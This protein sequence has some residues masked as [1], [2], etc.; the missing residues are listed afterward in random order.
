M[1]T[2]E[3]IVAKALE[4]FNERSVEYVGLRELAAVLGMRVSNIT[5]YFPT[6]DDLVNRLVLDLSRLN[7]AL[8]HRGVDQTLLS[9]LLM[10][11]KVFENQIKYRCLL[12]SFVQ[13]MEQNKRVAAKY[14]ETQQKRRTILSDDLNNLIRN[15]YFNEKGAAQVDFLISTLALVSRFWISEAAVSYRHLSP[16]AQMNHYLS[17]V[18]R[19]FLPYV[20]PKGEKEIQEFLQGLGQI[21]GGPQQN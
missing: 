5:Y 4:M 9:F 7:S 13:I 15:G 11:Q 12:L 20:S 16:V 18:A 8:E 19:L 14:E 21:D 17:L 1:N 3:K 2:E 6:K 10:R